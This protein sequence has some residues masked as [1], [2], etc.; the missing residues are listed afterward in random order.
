MFDV[1]AIIKHILK[2]CYLSFCIIQCCL[3]IS[4]II[5]QFSWNKDS[6]EISYKK[7]RKENEQINYPTFSICTPG[8]DGSIFYPL[9]FTD[10]YH[11]LYKYAENNTP[12]INFCQENI[13]HW[14]EIDLY[15]RMLL[16]IENPLPEISKQHEA[17][18]THDEITIKLLDFMERFQFLGENTQWGYYF[19][20]SMYLSYQDSLRICFTKQFEPGMGTNHT[21]DLYGI[22]AEYLNLPLEVY[23]HQVGGLIEQ[24]GKKYVL[25]ITKTEIKELYA[26]WKATRRTSSTGQGITVF[27]DFHV[28]KIELLRKRPDAVEPCNESIDDNDKTYKEVVIKAV[29]CIP[30]YWKRFFENNTDENLLDCSTK[31][32]FE[33]LSNMLP[34]MYENTNL[35]NGSRLYDPP[36][37]EMKISATIHKRNERTVDHRLW[38][39]FY[40][41]ADEFIEI[42]NNEAYTYYD[43]W[44]QI[45]GLVGMYLGY[46]LL[47][48]NLKK[49]FN[50][51]FFLDSMQ[52]FHTMT[53]F[54]YLN[55][56]FS[57]TDS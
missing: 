54:T 50:V 55:H 56:T 49:L 35:L 48:V 43:L 42:V 40:Y 7:F 16:G 5:N 36:C 24:L 38:L 47:Q 30:S 12:N 3:M 22:N 17:N 1:K 44:S 20:E 8:V 21:Y 13:H 6:S 4:V 2:I 27:H 29:G 19:K 18:Y 33:Q 46:S 37:N 9:V 31:G 57:F 23:I 26:N 51:H 28:R 34:M 15:Q 52:H 14:C 11:V 41:D 25:L 45:G 39:G 10:L 53:K 32:Q